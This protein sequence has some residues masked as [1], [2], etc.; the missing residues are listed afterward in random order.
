MTT[1]TPTTLNWTKNDSG[2]YT[3]YGIGGIVFES[4]KKW[5]CYPADGEHYSVPSPWA[6]RSLSAAKKWFEKRAK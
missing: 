1:R 5:H 3:C 6:F 2:W 4:T